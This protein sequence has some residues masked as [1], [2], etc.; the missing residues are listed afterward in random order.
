M[1]SCRSFH[2]SIISMLRKNNID[3][4]VSPRFVISEA[5]DI[6]S[7]FIKQDNNIRKI[8]NLIEGFSEIPCLT[9]E[10]VPII[11]CS[12]IDVRL[13]D[14]M[15]K[16]TRKLPDV[17]STPFGGIFKTVASPNLS[18]FMIGKTPREW[19]NIQKREVKDKTK[20]YYFFIDGYFYIP[21]PKGQDLA[22]EEIRIEG[23][24]KDKYE[25]Y[26]F[27][28]QGCQDCKETC[29]KPLDFEFVA[30]F[31]LVDNIKKE[32]LDRFMRTYERIQPDTYPNQNSN[33][34]NGPLDG[35]NQ[36]R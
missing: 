9:L 30:P 17:F 36:R 27:N 21:I 16:S 8:F 4:W 29:P 23:Y 15:M 25:V 12:G 32:L 7:L 18:E 35:E 24:F 20:Y 5:R 34:K 11:S 33:E 6:A 13:C 31:Y 3:D 26:L 22:I 1:S 19:C 28:Q 2:S 14:K 10:E